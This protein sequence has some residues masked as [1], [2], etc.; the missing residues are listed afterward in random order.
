MVAPGEPVTI[1]L[2]GN[3]RFDE[4]GAARYVSLSDVRTLL[5]DGTAPSAH[6][7][8]TGADVTGL[9]LSPRSTEH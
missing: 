9:V 5:R 4:P 1:K 3:R 8:S 6:D 2:Y 7:A